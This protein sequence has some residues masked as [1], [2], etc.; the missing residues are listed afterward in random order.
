MRKPLPP[1]IVWCRG[2]LPDHIVPTVMHQ[3][4]RETLEPFGLYIRLFLF[5]LRLLSSCLGGSA[6]LSILHARTFVPNNLDLYV[7]ENRW[8]FMKWFLRAHPGIYLVHDPT[9]IGHLPY[10]AAASPSLSAIWYFKNRR[11]G[12]IIR[13]LVTATRHVKSPYQEYR[14]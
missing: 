2:R 8:I 13:V 10:G 12:N 6:V 11:T 7:P 9:S 14:N 5:A 4:L 1:A 3:R